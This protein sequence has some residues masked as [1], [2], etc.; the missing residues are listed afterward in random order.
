MMDVE[1]SAVALAGF[2][3]GS[4]LR[5]SFL[6]VTGPAIAVAIIGSVARHI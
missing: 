6:G 4:R 5:D 3:G 2:V 1:M